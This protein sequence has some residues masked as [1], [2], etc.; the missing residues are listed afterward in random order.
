MLQDR[1]DDCVEIARAQIRD[2]AHLLDLCVDYVGRDGVADM[3]QIASRLATSS[4][5][6]IMLDSTE[7]AVL[8]AGLQLLGGRCALN[9]V[10]FEDGEGPE[11]R[12]SRIASLAAEYGAALVGLTID[13]TGQARTAE[14]KVAVA[15]RLLGTLEERYGIPGHD[16]LIDCL[17]FTLAT[18]QE[19]SRRD[20]VETIEAIRELKRR[21][22]DVQ[23]VLGL[24]NISFGLSPASTALRACTVKVPQPARAS[25]STNRCTNSYA[26][27]RSMPRR[28]LTVTGIDT[29]SCI[30][31]KQS[32]TSSGSAIRHAPNAPRCT[33]SEGQPQF[34]LISS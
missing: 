34:R 22:P 25:V 1:W 4:T 9:S 6:P 20:G 32:A 18:G 26:S 24:S 28:C 3:R 7:P 10:N 29:A 5:L 8:E 19:E 23:T 27:L 31:F 33:R 13:E 12:F 11:S 17:T 2:G 21:R 30:A 16:V 14:H 15:E